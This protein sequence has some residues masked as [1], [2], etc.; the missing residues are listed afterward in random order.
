VFPERIETP[1]LR[2]DRLTPDR[3]DHAEL[4]DAL[5]GERAEAITRYL[6]RGPHD[7]PKDTADALEGALGEWDEAERARWAIFPR[8]GEDGAGESVGAATLIPL[9]EEDVGLTGVWLRPRVW[10]RGYSGERAAAL[11]RVAFEWLDVGAVSPGCVDDNERS[12]RAIEKYVDR[13]GGRYEGCLR[14]H[15]HD[16]STDEPRDMHRWTVAREEYE[17]AI[18]DG[19]GVDVTVTRTIDGAE[20]D[21]AGG[22]AEP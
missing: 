20:P 19:A 22:A 15:V 6:G 12:R 9:W 17:A 16:R 21:R 7:H 13:F 14:N 10:G 8:P 3:V 4:Y 2:L 5:G 11:M 18:A 1:R